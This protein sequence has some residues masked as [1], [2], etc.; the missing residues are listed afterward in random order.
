MHAGRGDLTCSVVVPV[1]NEERTIRQSV[2]RLLKAELPLPLEVIVVDDGSTDGSVSAIEDLVDSG[3]VRLLRHPQNAGKGAAVRTAI[4][5]ATG[6]ILTILDADLEYTPDD[7]GALLGP[8]VSGETS[9]VYG[10]RTYKGHTAYSFWYVLGNRLVNFW[11]SFLFNTWLSDVETCFKVAR[12]ELWRRL[13]LTEN[14]FGIEAE[15]TAKFLRAGE[16][17]YEI[18][19][20]YRARTRSEGKKLRWTDG[21]AALVIALRVRLLGR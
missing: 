2:D 12:T 21:V 8:I 5:A 16:R 17:I 19:I 13:D 10:T 20:E 11:L 7:Y 1:F 6:E 3:V 15:A 4:A 14:G 18:P 9:V